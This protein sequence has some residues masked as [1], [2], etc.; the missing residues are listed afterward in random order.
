MATQGGAH[1][2]GLG[3]RIGSLEPGKRADLVLFRL[4]APH[5]VPLFDP[6]SHLAYTLHDS[7]VD[8]V[9]VEGQVIYQGGQFA[10]CDVAGAQAVVQKIAARIRAEGY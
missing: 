2:A 8:T 10:H 9:I 1:A 6:Y 3:D 4:D 5:A 7:D